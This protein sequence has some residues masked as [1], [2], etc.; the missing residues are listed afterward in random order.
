MAK[1]NELESTIIEV[2][3]YGVSKKWKVKPFYSCPAFD[4]LTNKYRTG[5]ENMTPEELAKQPFII[6]P[7]KNIIIRDGET[8]KLEKKG[9]EFVTSVDYT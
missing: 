7:M 6:D 9:G 8:L 4:Q 5:Q 3:V 2:K 1:K